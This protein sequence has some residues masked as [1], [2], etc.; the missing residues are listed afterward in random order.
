MIRELAEELQMEY[1]DVL[2]GVVLEEAM[3]R[4]YVSQ[5]GS[6]MYLLN[7]ECLGKEAY[8]QGK[9]RALK[10]YYQQNDMLDSSNPF[11]PGTPMNWKMA[12][13]LIAMIF[14]TDPNRRISWKGMAVEEKEFFQW[15]LVATVEEK[16]VPISIML[17]PLDDTTEKPEERTLQLMTT[18][19]R[20]T[21]FHYGVEIT[22]A[23]NYLEI[24]EKLEL[25][26][27]MEAYSQVDRIL[28]ENAI[29]GRLFMERVEKLLTGRETLKKEK[30]QEQLA[31]YRD[32]TYMRKR[33]EQYARRN[34]NHRTWEDI[35]AEL[36]RFSEPVWHAICKDEVFLEDWMPELGRFLV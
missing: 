28:N 4:I 12:T 21:Y 29:S 20:L 7:S 14:Y 33:W 16:E 26:P 34:A 5:Y 25:I 35:I 9:D 17:Y 32:Y 22:L 27:N 24:M 19:E 18:G 15:N 31:S 11:A 3:S 6:H 8:R 36:L 13:Y 30:R 23:K 1:A 2:R 10:F